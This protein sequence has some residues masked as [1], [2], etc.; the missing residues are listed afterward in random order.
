MDQQPHPFARFV[1]ILGRGK[2]FTRSLKLDDA[3]KAMAAI[4]DCDVPPERRGAF[5]RLLRLKE[6]SA[7]EIAGLANAARKRFAPLSVGVDVDW[8]SYAG[9]RRQSPRFILSAFDELWPP[10]I[11]EPRQAANAQAAHPWANCERGRLLAAA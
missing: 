7:E 8:A 5:P 11:G 2:N 6:E 9:K 1:R 10:V 4:L 3:E